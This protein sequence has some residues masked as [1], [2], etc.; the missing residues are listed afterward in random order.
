[1]GQ[2]LNPLRVKKKIS[3]PSQT[4]LLKLK[5]IPL[6][7]GQGG[8]PKKTCPIAIPWLKENPMLFRHLLSN[9]LNP[10]TIY[11]CFFS[12]LHFFQLGIFHHSLNLPLG[13][14]IPG[15]GCPFSTS[16]RLFHYPYFQIQLW[17]WPFQGTWIHTPSLIISHTATSVRRRTML[18]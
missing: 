16:Y 4:H 10:C 14:F 17:L 5:L 15:S 1:M 18:R 9:G 7:T 11:F 3:Y 6:R 12:W 2:Y 8:Y 13:T